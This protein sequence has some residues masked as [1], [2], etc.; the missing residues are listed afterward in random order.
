MSEKAWHG[1]YEKNTAQLGQV[2]AVLSLAVPST[3]NRSGKC[4]DINASK[5]NAL[6][7]AVL[8]ASLYCFLARAC[9]LIKL[10]L[11]TRTRTDI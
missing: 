3:T 4:H 1:S 9:A 10:Q 2:D 11:T 6:K 8:N 5:Q 7:N